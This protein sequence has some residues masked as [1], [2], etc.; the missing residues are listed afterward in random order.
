MHLENT[1]EGNGISNALPAVRYVPIAWVL[2]I[3][4]AVEKYSHNIREV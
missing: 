1:T 3:M 2:H 4:V